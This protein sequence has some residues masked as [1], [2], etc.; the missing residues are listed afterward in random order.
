M[1]NMRVV[2][3]IPG[4]ELAA[5]A[6]RDAADQSPAAIAKSERVQD[7]RDGTDRKRKSRPSM[8]GLV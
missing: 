7:G 3:A 1:V 2:Y 4:G 6:P 5:G 8:S